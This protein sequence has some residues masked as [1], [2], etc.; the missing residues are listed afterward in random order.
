MCC[1]LINYF[2]ASPVTPEGIYILMLKLNYVTALELIL[3][4]ALQGLEKKTAN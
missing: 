1:H 4:L 3:L 2:F